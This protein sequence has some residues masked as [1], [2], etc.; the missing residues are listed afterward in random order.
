[1]SAVDVLAEAPTPPP[2]EPNPTP[3]P[4]ASPP[5]PTEPQP[6]VQNLPLLMLYRDAQGKQH[7]LIAG[8]GKGQWLLPKLDEVPHEDLL[9]HQHTLTPKD[10][11]SILDFGQNK[12]AL[13]VKNHQVFSWVPLGLAKTILGEQFQ[14]VL[15]KDVEL[16]QAQAPIAA[17]DVAN[18]DAASSLQPTPHI[19]GHG[20][21]HDGVREPTQ[22][23]LA[24]HANSTHIGALRE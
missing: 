5:A 24:M 8:D 23:M 21:Q 20:A 17:L 3:E 10:S 2:A 14:H 15:P 9:T 7:V 6:K 4:P 12:P 16:A 19:Q 1:M 22:S 11:F 13:N 18:V